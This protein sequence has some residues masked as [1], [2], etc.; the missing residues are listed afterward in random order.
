MTTVYNRASVTLSSPAASW[1][2]FPRHAIPLPILRR[3]YLVDIGQCGGTGTLG[4][5]CAYTNLSGVRRVWSV[6]G[7]PFVPY[8]GSSIYT[9]NLGFTLGASLPPTVITGTTTALLPTTATI[10]GTVNANGASTAVTFRLWT[11]IGLWK[12]PSRSAPNRDRHD[13]HPGFRRF[14]EHILPGIRPTTTG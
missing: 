1:F 9:Y 5:G 13:Q 6:G 12:Y 3:A 14:S 8:N 7:C 4:G 10:N 11:D 2:T